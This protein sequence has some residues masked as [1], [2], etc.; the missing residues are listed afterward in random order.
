MTIKRKLIISMSIFLFVLILMG[1][2][3][4]QGYHYVT[5]KASIANDL[6]QEIMYLQ[7]MLRGL[8]EIIINEGTPTSIKTARTGVDGFTAIHEK[9]MAEI[10]DP[11]IKLRLREINRQWHLIASNFTPFLDHY[12]EMSGDDTLIMAGN[13]ISKSEIMIIHIQLLSDKVRAVVNTNSEISEF[14][15]R[16]MIGLLAIL[17]LLSIL[18]AYQVYLSINR[19]IAELLKIADGFE[20]GNLTVSM[21]ESRR[22]EFGLLARAFNHSITKLNEA[23][24]TLHE[25]GQELS[26]S[27]IKLNAEITE[28]K[29]AEERISH[30]AYY[31]SLTGLPNR[32]LLQDRLNMSISQYE[33]HEQITAILFLDIDNFKRINDTLGHST[34]DFL[35]KG[36]ADRLNDCIRA[37]DTLSRKIIYNN[38]ESTVSRLGGDEYTILAS[39][40]KNP[41]D[42]ARVA[43]RVM[44]E[45]SQPF[46]IGDNELYIT[47]SMGIAICPNDG[48]DVDTLLKN[49]DTAMYHAKSKG[50]NN[51]QFYE[52]SMN[53]LLRKRLE[54]EGDLRKAIHGDELLLHYQPRIDTHTG[55]ISSME[56]LV[57]WERPG[58]GLVS[59]D[60]FIPVA[61]DTGL[62]VPL[63]EWVLKSAC[64]QNKKWQDAGL[65]PIS[66]S[67][68]ISGKQFQEDNFLKKISTI[69]EESSLNP[70]WLELEITENVLMHHAQITAEILHEIKEMGIRLSMDDFGTGYSSFNYL[71]SFPLDIIKIDKSFIDE[72]PQNPNDATIVNAI[73]SM[74]HNL[75]LH[76]VAEGVELEQQQIFLR[77]HGCDEIQG[78]Y[79]SKPLP[80]KDFAELLEKSVHTPFE[81]APVLIGS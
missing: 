63:G 8:N 20:K 51:F 60:E 57:R 34:G 47:V 2:S 22:D 24:N 9:L 79:Y 43:Q 31:D 70:K 36:V 27:N 21:D 50:K 55:H 4:L 35:L 66:M 3:L 52:E 12:I 11:V 17:F 1:F 54:L 76:V 5:D 78:Y 62:I 13:L 25:R 75:N 69:I 26:E 67:V 65:P 74:A 44:S 48:K 23:T 64:M 14:V 29:T 42:A 19:P 72:I 41:R 30:M 80:V 46:A 68:N 6:D 49:A 45:I 81:S 71:K 15:E 38:E 58:K 33:R 18:V 56:A 59:P 39:N 37:T 73:I 7:K 10:A 53:A 32:H 61:E 77:D 28:R 40:I 16:A